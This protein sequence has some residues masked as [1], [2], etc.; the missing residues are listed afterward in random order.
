[1]R[2]VAGA[3]LFLACGLGAAGVIFLAR[4][5]R[6]LL[7]AYWVT[8]VSKE[9]GSRNRVP[10]APAVRRAD[11]YWAGATVTLALLSLVVGMSFI[12]T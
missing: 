7:R 12:P 10:P 4:A 9:D 6:P 8:E 1:M 11:I 3:F 2:A 5:T